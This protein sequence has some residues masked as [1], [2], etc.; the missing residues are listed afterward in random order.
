M[1]DLLLAIREVDEEIRQE[2]WWWFAGLQVGGS[3]PCDLLSN[4]IVGEK[5]PVRWAEMSFRLV[6]KVPEI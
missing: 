4:L 2:E 5:T 6:A 3:I 1:F